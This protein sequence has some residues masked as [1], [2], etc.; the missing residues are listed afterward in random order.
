MLPANVNFVP[1]FYKDLNKLKRIP[2]EKDLELFKQAVAIEPTSLNGIVRLQ[3]IGEEY[4]PVYKARK[5][6]CRALNRGNRSGIRIIYTFNP[7]NNEVIL[8]EIYYKEDKT[9]HDVGRA[10]KY[11]IKK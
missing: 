11:S 1:E 4:Y 9:N 3:G 5:F 8:I 7:N 6:R 10:K 2:L